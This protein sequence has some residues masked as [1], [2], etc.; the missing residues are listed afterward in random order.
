[1]EL[2]ESVNIIYLE[3]L[4]SLKSVKKLQFLNFFFFARYHNYFSFTPCSKP[5]G[6]CLNALMEL[7]KKGIYAVLGINL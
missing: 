3:R 2:L 4:F 1:M 7:V 6:I 5:S